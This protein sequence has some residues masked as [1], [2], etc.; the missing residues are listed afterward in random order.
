V[1]T[2]DHAAGTIENTLAEATVAPTPML[3]KIAR[4]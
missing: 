1:P 2:T 4:M 3:D